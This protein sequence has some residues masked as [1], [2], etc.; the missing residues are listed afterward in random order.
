MSYVPARADLIWV[1]FDPQAGREQAGRRPALVLSR[2]YYNERVGLA[3]ICPITS[4]VK[5]FPYEVALPEGLPVRGVA[6]ADQTS[7]LD[8]R[9]RNP[10]FIAQAPESLVDE[11][12]E[13]L[14]TLIKV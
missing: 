6:L 3:L 2:T 1:N 12:V 7:S 11:V 14:I 8:W 5:G 4:R 10:Q 9:V 13:R